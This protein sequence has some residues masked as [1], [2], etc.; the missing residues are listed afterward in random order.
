MIRLLKFIASIATIAVFMTVFAHCALEAWD[1]EEK[2]KTQTHKERL[3][4][5]IQ[6]GEDVPYTTNYDPRRK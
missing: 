2:L 4:E 3:S 5:M 6:S 1:K